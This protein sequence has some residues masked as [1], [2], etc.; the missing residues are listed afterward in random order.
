MDYIMEALSVAETNRSVIPESCLSFSEMA[1][2]LTE[3]TNSELNNI[4]ESIGIDELKYFEK[5]GSIKYYD[6][7]ALSD[8]KAKFANHIKDVWSAYKN[9]WEKVIS[10]MQQDV[11]QS[12]SLGNLSKA[13]LDTIKSYGK[14]HTFFKASDIKFDANAKKFYENIN[15]V[16][17]TISDEN[18]DKIKEGKSLLSDEVCSK[19]SGVEAKSNSS[20][21]KEL[22]KKLIGAEVEANYA[23]VNKNWSNLTKFISTGGVEF[24]KTAYNAE[25]AIFAEFTKGIDSFDNDMTSCAGAWIVLVDMTLSTMHTCYATA[26]DV[27]RRR[28]KEYVNIATKVIGNKPVKEAAQDVPQDDN[29]DFKEV[30]DNEIPKTTSEEDYKEVQEAEEVKKN[31]DGTEDTTADTVDTDPDRNLKAAGLEEAAEEDDKKEEEDTPDV[32]EM[33]DLKDIKESAYSKQFDMINKAFDF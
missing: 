5:N 19:I 29:N 24:A 21:K 8:F 20:M 12:K 31:D 2:Y 14:T 15:I 16:F 32:S 11:K 1:G 33:D 3:F 23:W 18:A 17:T 30:P 22:K 25:K 27:Y 26:I 10:A 7:A 9:F 28:F 13:D 4:L 6:E